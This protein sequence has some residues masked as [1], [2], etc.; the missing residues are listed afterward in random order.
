MAP[1]AA[2]GASQAGDKQQ[3]TRLRDADP[4]HPALATLDV[5]GHRD[6]LMTLATLSAPVTPAPGTP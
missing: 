2:R 6:I 3:E 1:A 4:S 5:P